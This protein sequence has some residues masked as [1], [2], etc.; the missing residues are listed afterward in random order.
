MEPDS[1]F[2]NSGSMF[3]PLHDIS[4][5]TNCSV[6]VESSEEKS[7]EMIDK[8]LDSTLHSFKKPRT[9]REEARKPYLLVS[10][11]K[12]HLN[13]ALRNASGLQLQYLRRNLS[14][15]DNLLRSF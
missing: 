2:T 13:S 7:E 11:K 1:L 15:F 4:Y 14:A 6:A 10:K 5:C 8:I 12:V 9:Y 3:M